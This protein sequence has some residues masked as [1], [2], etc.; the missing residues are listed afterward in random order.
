M[1]LKV[2]TVEEVVVGKGAARAELDA[3]NLAQVDKADALLVWSHAREADALSDL[4]EE[5]VAKA[6]LG[7]VLL[8]KDAQLPVAIFVTA[9]LG[10]DAL[11][12][13]AAVDEAS[14]AFRHLDDGAV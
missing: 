1:N 14:S 10:D 3:A 5:D 2:G 8:V 11:D 4:A 13:T 12:A 6:V 7:A 9:R